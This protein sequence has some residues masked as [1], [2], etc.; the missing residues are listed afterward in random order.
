MRE[1]S[2]RGLRAQLANLVYV[3]AAAEALPAELAS[4]CDQLTVVLPWGSLLAATARPSVED[5]RGIRALC[6]PAASLTVVLSRHPLRDRAELARLEIPSLDPA[7]LANAIAPGYGEAGFE[8]MR[9]RSMDA[10]ELSRWGSTW[11]RRLSFAG[12]RSF[13]R[14][15]ARAG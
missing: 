5:L 8:R 12:D 3:R 2:G 1:F 7:S 4:A 6:R 14:I 10:R 9:V 15:D 11:V 13:V